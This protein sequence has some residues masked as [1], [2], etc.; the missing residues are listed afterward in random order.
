MKPGLTN[1]EYVQCLGDMAVEGNGDKVLAYT[2]KWLDLVNRGGLFPLNDNSFS[3]FVEIE[4]IVRTLL[5]RHAVHNDC[6][7]QTFWR[8]AV[9]KIASNDDVQFYWTLLSHDIQ[10][11]KDSEILLLVT[12]WVTVRGY[13][14][15]AAWMEEYKRSKQKTTEKA[16][17]LRKSIY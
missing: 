4:R 11:Q 16:P 17:G 9:D 13:S 6:E 5:A 1:S 2:R 7:K 3:F 15:A 14:L 12:L 10:E 8:S